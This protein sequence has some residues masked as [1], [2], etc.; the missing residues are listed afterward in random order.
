MDSRVA[1]C[2]WVDLGPDSHSPDHH[3]VQI[4]ETY[5]TAVRTRASSRLAARVVHTAFSAPASSTP[6]VTLFD[7]SP[8]LPAHVTLDNIATPNTDLTG[9]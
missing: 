9:R 6:P 7:K 8:L 3:T 4:Q 1:H 2:Y 5:P